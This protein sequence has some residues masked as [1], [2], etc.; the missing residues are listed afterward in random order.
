MLP[1]FCILLSVVQDLTAQAPSAAGRQ[2]PAIW[3][4]VLFEVEHLEFR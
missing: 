1:V 2:L 4:G 3:A